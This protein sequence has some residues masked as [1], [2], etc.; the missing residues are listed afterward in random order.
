MLAHGSTQ[1]FVGQ[2][3]DD[4]EGESA[5]EIIDIGRLP[6]AEVDY[7]ALGDW[8]GTKQVG[9]KAWQAGTPEP[10][11]FTKE[12][13]HDPGN[14]LVVDVVRGSLPVVTRVHTAKLG[15]TELQFDLAD[16]SALGRLEERLA[17]LMGQRTNQDL[18]KLSLTGTIGF[19]AS[20][21]LDRIVESL[22]AASAGQ[23][24]Q[25]DTV[26]SHAGGDQRADR[27]RH[28]PLIFRVAARLVEEA[29]GTDDAAVVARAALR[30]LHTA[31][32]VERAS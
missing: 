16:D 6:D 2:W 5:A 3:D 30:Q 21:H 12:D 11:R 14:V 29:A 27:A 32:T 9:P 10:D 15:W 19:E 4:G 22:Q 25:R 31:L 24:G 28:R 1:T 20:D 26:G 17:S 8:H 7:V 23:A 18:L 13:D